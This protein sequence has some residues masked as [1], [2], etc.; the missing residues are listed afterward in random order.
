ME[1]H[2]QTPTADHGNAVATAE[3]SSADS[4]AAAGLIPDEGARQSEE[5]SV[6]VAGFA[7]GM[8]IAGIFL[9]YI[10]MEAGKLLP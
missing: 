2:V 1:G 3:H 10:I 7:T 4:G 6:L 8:C 5:L 9:I